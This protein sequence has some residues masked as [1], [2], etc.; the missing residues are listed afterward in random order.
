MA[1]VF[2]KLGQEV[3]IEGIN[4]EDAINEGIRQGYQEG[5]LRKSVVADPFIRDKYKG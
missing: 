3:H 4:L 2:I 5:Y 1:I